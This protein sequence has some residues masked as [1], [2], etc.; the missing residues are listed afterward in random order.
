MK[1]T[2]IQKKRIKL[3]SIVLALSILLASCI[4]SI[5]YLNSMSNTNFNKSNDSVDRQ[6]SKCYINCSS[7]FS[8]PHKSIMIDY[9][10]FNQKLD[11]AIAENT[12]K[13]RLVEEAER[14]ELARIEAELIKVEAEKKRHREE[15]EKERLRRQEEK[16]KQV[17]VVSRG[18]KEAFGQ[19]IQFEA[20][21]YGSDCYKCSGKTAYGINVQSTIYHNGLRIIAV[22]PNVIPLGSI[23]EVKTPNEAFKAIAGDTGGRINGFIIDVLVESE[24]ASIKYGRHP[25]QVRIL[26]SK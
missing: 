14:I 3:Y 6:L 1:I 10:S 17:A 4:A 11:L 23:V 22:D 15:L 8:S 21:Y 12:E 9:E 7:I 2:N 16:K 19:W 20:T 25:V 26:K 13:I 18:S 5:N 24:A